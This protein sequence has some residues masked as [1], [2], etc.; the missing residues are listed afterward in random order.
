MAVNQFKREILNRLIK[1]THVLN[2][3]ENKTAIASDLGINT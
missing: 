3:H 1:Y 2:F